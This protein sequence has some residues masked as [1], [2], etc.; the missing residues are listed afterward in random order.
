MASW[1][2]VVILLLLLLLLLPHSPALYSF[3][4][5]SEK[6]TLNETKGRVKAMKL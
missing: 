3:L 6:E 2:A 4:H 1:S 5:I